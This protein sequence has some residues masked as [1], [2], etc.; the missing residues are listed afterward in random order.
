[1]GV[2]QRDTATTASSSV[3]HSRR[4]PF[5]REVGSM[6]V[7]TICIRKAVTFFPQASNFLKPWKFVGCKQRYVS[8]A[9]PEYVKA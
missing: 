5:L 7:W 3:H 1:M 2:G 6:L 9:C 8:S 4:W